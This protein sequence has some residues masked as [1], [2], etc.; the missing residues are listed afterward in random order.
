MKR[1]VPKLTTDE[2]AEAFLDE[3]LSDLEKGDATVFEK[4]DAT[5]FHEK[6]TEKGTRL[7]SKPVGHR[8]GL[9]LQLT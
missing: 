3:D 6:G 5:L 7:F 1:K 4:G 2:E 8:F 9:R